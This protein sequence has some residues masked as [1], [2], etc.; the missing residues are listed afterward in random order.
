MPT[1]EDVLRA[2]SSVID[3]ELGRDLVSL[4]MIHD[5]RVE[6]EVARFTL[7]LTTPACPI[8]DHLEQMA[9]LAVAKLP[10]IRDVH[11]KVEA[12]EGRFSNPFVRHKLGASKMVIFAKL[13]YFL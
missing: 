6:N 7:R 1:S 3:P 4:E 10:G 13:L 8:R 11:V 2:L 12:V 9:R 5:V